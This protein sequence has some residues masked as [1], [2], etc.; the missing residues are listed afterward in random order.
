MPADSP[1]TSDEEKTAGLAEFPAPRAKSIELAD[2]GQKGIGRRQFLRL[3]GGAAVGAAAYSILEA[4]RAN[5][6]AG[7][8]RPPGA[9]PEPG[10][11]AA[12]LRCGKCV[13]ACPYRALRLAGGGEGLSLGTPYIA[14][15]R[16][17]PCRLC[18]AQHCIKACPTGALAPLRD[19]A[20]AR[21]GLA[22][23]DEKRCLAYQGQY[24]LVCYGACPLTKVAMIVDQ[25]LRPIVVKDKC[26]GCG[27]CEYACVLDPAA[28]V[29]KKR[30]EVERS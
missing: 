27:V 7:L 5:A 15:P 4:G 14:A 24:C 9:L 12:C 23:R 26:T 1:P 2:Q 21:M 30:S 3:I 20:E 8:I 19:I 22:V 25:Q 17:F 10:F 28:I 18:Q 11:L 6:G 13:Q 29:V 16:Q